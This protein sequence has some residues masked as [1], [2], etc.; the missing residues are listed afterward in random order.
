MLA[1]TEET[2]RTGWKVGCALHAVPVCWQHAGNSWLLTSPTHAFCMC[3]LLARSPHNSWLHAPPLQLGKLQE[4]QPLAADQE[5]APASSCAADEEAVAAREQEK[6]LVSFCQ[7]LSCGACL[8]VLPFR[9][10]A[11]THR[12]AEH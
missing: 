12:R 11:K 8:F 3:E 2:Q 9:V 1:C 5:A 4:L 10:S 6:E 7:P